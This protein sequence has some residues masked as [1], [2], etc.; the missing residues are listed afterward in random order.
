MLFLYVKL[1]NALIYRICILVFSPKR[2]FPDEHSSEHSNS[3]SSVTRSFSSDLNTRNSSCISSN[4]SSRNASPAPASS[5]PSS[6]PSPYHSI[7]VN[8][9]YSHKFKMYNNCISINKLF[10]KYIY[11]YIIIIIY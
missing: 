11:I 10:Y 3:I 9:I 7:K 5:T 8:Y 4:K 6:S 2:I 1:H